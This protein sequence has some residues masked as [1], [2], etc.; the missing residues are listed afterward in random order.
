MYICTWITCRCIFSLK[1]VQKA[2]EIPLECIYNVFILTF[3]RLWNV[4]F[5]WSTI[6]TF[7][8]V[9]NAGVLLAPAMDVFLIVWLDRCGALQLF[10]S[11]QQVW[12][13]RGQVGQWPI[14][15]HIITAFFIFFA[16][17]FVSYTI[18]IQIDYKC[19]NG[20]IICWQACLKGR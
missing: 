7:T 4:Y 8:F 16:K 14:C 3:N 15:V 12:I 2:I 19:K 17:C 1:V 13:F 20:H 9:F 6:S 18:F 11:S 10:L 5:F